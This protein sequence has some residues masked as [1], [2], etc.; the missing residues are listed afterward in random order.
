ME[1]R[2]LLFQHPKISLLVKDLNQTKSYLKHAPIEGA[3]RAYRLKRTERTH[4]KIFP[5]F[6]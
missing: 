6:P 2:S 5:T 3:V 1:P 4:F